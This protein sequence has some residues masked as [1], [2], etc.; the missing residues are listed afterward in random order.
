MSY[1]REDF[2]AALA[3]ELSNYPAV[4]QY[5]QAGD[6]RILANL[7]AM[8][9]MM[10]LLSQQIDVESMEP[11]TKVRDTTVLADAA[12]KGILPFARPPRMTVSIVNDG[13]SALQIDIGRRFIDQQGHIYVAETN[14]SIAAGQTGLVN[15][16][17][18][19]ARV[20]THT[21]SNSVPFYQVVIPPSTDSELFIS[22]VIVKIGGVLYP[23]VPEFANMAVGQVGFTLETDEYRRLTAKFGWQSTFGMQPANGTVIE[24]TIE[25]TFGQTTLPVDAAFTFETIVQPQDQLAKIRLSSVIYPGANPL[26]IDTLREYAKYPS[27]YD[28]TAVY[29]GNF[30]FLVRRNL[31]PLRFLSIW[32]EQVEESVRG[33]SVNNINRLFVSAL[34][35]NVDTTWMQNEIR[36]IIKAAD[37]SYWIKFVTPVEVAVPITVNAQVSVVHDVG[38]VQAKI[39]AVIYSLYGRDSEAAKKG[40]LMLNNKLISDALRKQVAALQD[41]GSDFQVVIPA[42]SSMLPE[43]FR[44]VSAASLTVNVTQ[45]T[46]ND[47][48]WSH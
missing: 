31:F 38:D 48:M 3:A 34:M 21:V 8:A 19:T 18:V 29:L 43:Q 23:Y 25:E 27:L 35:D 22:G 40:M 12:M 39:R 4:A 45:S 28:S 20:F 9:T 30:D 46:Y 2:M 33:P 37:D 47:G 41:T 1:S 17:Q 42:Q 44:Y 6:P 26:S 36:R 15:L 24:F 14:V 5:Y 10:A 7:G 16:K 32:N 13:I 11:F